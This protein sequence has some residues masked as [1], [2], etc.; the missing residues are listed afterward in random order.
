[1]GGDNLGEAGA[2]AACAVE[3]GLRDPAATEDGVGVDVFAVATSGTERER[4]EALEGTRIVPSLF[5]CS[6]RSRLYRAS[7]S[8]RS[9]SALALSSSNWRRS[10]VTDI[11]N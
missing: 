1:M 4:G 2:A 6:N 3:G 7:A 10:A 5:A 9:K 8:A 11:G